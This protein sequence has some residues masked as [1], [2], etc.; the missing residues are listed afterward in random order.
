MGKL[1]VLMIAGV[2]VLILAGVTLTSMTLASASA[3]IYEVP[4]DAFASGG[5]RMVSDNYEMVST[6]GQELAGDASSSAYQLAAGFWLVIEGGRHTIY[7]PLVL[8]S[9]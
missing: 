3:G 2:A 9:Y 4:W 7:L 1:K 6:A 8:R 5:E